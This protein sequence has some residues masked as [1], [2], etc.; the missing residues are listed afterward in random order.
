MPPH[1]G[2]GPVAPIRA[3]GSCFFYSGGPR[4]NRSVTGT[5]PAALKPAGTGHMWPVQGVPASGRN[6]ASSLASLDIISPV[7]TDPIHSSYNI[8]I[9][10]FS[11]FLY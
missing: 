4:T 1:S 10:C 8:Q 9:Q 5:G 7:G 3:Q 11:L 2:A 6:Y